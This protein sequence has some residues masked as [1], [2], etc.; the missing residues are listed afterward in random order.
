M[1]DQTYQPHVYRKSGG[2]AL[3]IADGG[4]SFQRELTTAAAATLSVS[5]ALHDGRTI[6][7]NLAAG[8]TSTLPP[9]TGSGARFRFVVGPTALS[10]GSHV[11]KVASGTDYMRGT[12]GVVASAG[13]GAAKAWA[14][15]DSGTVATESDTI[16]LNGTT[17]S[18]FPGTEV[19]VE[20]IAANVWAVVISGKASGTEATPFSAAV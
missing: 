16:T 9:A 5:Q 15:A 7:L 4:G 12:A 10:G 11:I 19:E 8:I 13:A 14:T 1:S 17:T 6:V 2:D 18:G 3:V 20:D